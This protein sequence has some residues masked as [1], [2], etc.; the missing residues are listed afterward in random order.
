VKF[1][2]NP[3]VQWTSLEQKQ[4]FLRQKGLTDEEISEACQR[5]AVNSSTQIQ[6][7]PISLPS[8]PPPHPSI[9]YQSKPELPLWLKV[10]EIGNV[11]AL[12]SLGSYGLYSLWKSHVAPWLFGR[13]SNTDQK[14]KILLAAITNL[15]ESI[16]EL[17]ALIFKLDSHLQSQFNQNERRSFS[18]EHDETRRSKEVMALEEVREELSSIK[19]LLVSR[20]QFPSSPGI[21][22]WQLVEKEGTSQENSRDQSPHPNEDTSTRRKGGGSGESE[23]RHGRKKSSS[24]SHESIALH[25]DGSSCEVVMIGG[26]QD[27]SDHSD[28]SDHN[29][30]KN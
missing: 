23:S 18:G 22:S 13:P 6:E 12:L 26:K 8:V 21:P 14:N 2:G 16:G 1:L 24:G 7:Q 27:S 5:A 10:K 15:T 29:S 19:A 9:T 25:S 28:D 17:R 20:A 30:L 4:N 11:I 3:R